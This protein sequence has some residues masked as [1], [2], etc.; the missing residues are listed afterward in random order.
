MLTVS[1]LQLILVIR[2]ISSYIWTCSE[3]FDIRN[4]FE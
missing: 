4:E 2:W 1:I 3:Y